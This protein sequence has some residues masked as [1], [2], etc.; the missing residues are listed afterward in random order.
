VNT[1]SL[2]RLADRAEGVEGRRA[3]RLTEVHGRIRRARRR[4]AAIGAVTAVATVALVVAGVALA[5]STDRSQEP[6]GP[7][8]PQPTPTETVEAPSGQVTLRPEIGP[9]DIRGWELRASRTNSEPDY[10]G[11]TDLSLTVETGGLYAFQSHIVTF[12]NGDPNTWWVLT[13]DLGGVEGG[14]NPDGSMQ[15]GTRGMF[16]TCSQDDPIEV[17]GP[18]GNIE[19]QTRNYR[20]AAMAYPLRMFVTDEVS[21]AAQQCLNRTMDTDA[22]LSTH[23]LTPLGDTDATFGFGVYEHKAAPVVLS[24]P[25]IESQALTMADGVEYLVDRAVVSAPGSPR[26]VVAMPA[27]DRSRIVAVYASGTAALEECAEGL[28]HRKPPQSA[29]EEQAQV[30]E[31]DRKCNTELELRLDGQRPPFPEHDFYFGDQ[32]VVLPPGDA[33]TV[34]IEVTKNDPR[35]VRYAL[36]IWEAR[37]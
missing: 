22:C 8:T 27:S 35:N 15:D 34:T 11:A 7:N 30:E 9:G 18:T 13:M 37:S 32:Q 26:L 12:C 2:R 6:V 21:T 25:N 28:G 3:D 20:E 31:F 29:E 17:P 33:R 10:A 4:R 5:G 24:G 19:P 36:V 23:G 16:G 14:R 1:E